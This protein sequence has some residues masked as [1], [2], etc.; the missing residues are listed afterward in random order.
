MHSFSELTEIS[1]HFTLNALHQ[2]QEV[3]SKQFE[4]SS[5]TSLVK[6][7]QMLRLQKIIFA[8]GMFSIFEAQLQDGLGGKYGF[9]EVAKILEN[10][11]K[12]AL[13]EK[14]N[15]Y[16]DAINALKHGD[17]K[18]YQKLVEKIPDLHFRVKDRGQVFFEE[19]DISEINAL[20]DVDDT[21]IEGCTE[22]IREVTEVIRT[23]R[24]DYF[25]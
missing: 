2:A 17:G 7:A 8:V 3:L 16:K 6:R 20:I 18:S 9:S 21:F 12:S 25:G 4:T 13:Q 1:S 14:F 5:A 19:G 23:V 22:T 11:G 10:E 24:P 15:N